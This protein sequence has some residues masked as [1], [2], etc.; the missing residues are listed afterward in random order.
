MQNIKYIVNILSV[1]LKSVLKAEVTHMISEVSA[2][3]VQERY[4]SS[5][6]YRQRLFRP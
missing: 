6:S 4:F 3:G 1:T 2:G 5:V